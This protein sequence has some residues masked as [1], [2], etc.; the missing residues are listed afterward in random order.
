MLTKEELQQALADHSKE[1]AGM[2][3]S[4]IEAAFKTRDE[5]A[6]KAREAAPAEPATANPG[7]TYT[8]D[9]TNKLIAEASAKAE[10]KAREEFE[11]QARIAKRAAECVAAGALVPDKEII[12]QLAA[13]GSRELEDAHFEKLMAQAE[14]AS[15]RKRTAAPDDKP[16]SKNT[17]EYWEADF[18]ARAKAGEIDAPE[19]AVKR[20]KVKANYVEQSMKIPAL[21]N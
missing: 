21:S 12:K 9:E 17:A 3:D 10:T 1:I 16:K 6:A 5:N 19:D 2:V 11:R 4:K 20:A 15:V 7:A 18:E 13:C 8:A 14:L